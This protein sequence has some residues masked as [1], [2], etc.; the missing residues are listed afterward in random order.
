MVTSQGISKLRELDRADIYTNSCNNTVTLRVLDIKS[1][2]D[3][4]LMTL[5]DDKEQIKA[6]V[7]SHIWSYK[8]E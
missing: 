7:E 5:K 4:C 8:Y 6:T 1:R 2:F 3:T